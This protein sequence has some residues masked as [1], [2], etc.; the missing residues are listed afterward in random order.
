MEAKDHIQAA[1]EQCEKERDALDE[2]I[3]LLRIALTPKYAPKNGTKPK[4]KPSRKQETDPHLA[5]ENAI[6]LSVF[7]D[8]PLNLSAI[9]DAVNIT[10]APVSFNV[11][12]CLNRLVDSGELIQSGSGRSLRFL[13]RGVEFAGE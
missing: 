3:K 9:G 7:G 8:T 11:R 4:P 2:K 13:K 12:A 1:I 5:D 6:V 10:A